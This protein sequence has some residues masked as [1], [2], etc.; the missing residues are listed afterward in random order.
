MNLS[1]TS[2]TN[3]SVDLSLDGGLGLPLD[4]TSVEDSVAVMSSPAAD[5]IYQF[6]ALAFGIFLLAT[7]L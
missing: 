4:P 5:R 1:K 2:A 7:L 6:A 3:P